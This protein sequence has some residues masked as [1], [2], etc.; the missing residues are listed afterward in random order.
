[1]NVRRFTNFVADMWRPLL[2]YCGLF[3]AFAV[4]LFWRIGSL[5]PGY[6]AA[7]VQAFQA[8]SSLDAIFHDPINAPFTL[9]AHAL[10]YL[11]DRGYLL[12][13]L[14]ATV[15]GLITLA[16]FCWLVQRWYGRRT[17]LLSTIL[18]GTSAWFLH[19]ARMG[20]PDVLLFGVLTLV[21]CSV[22][23]RRTNNPIALLLCFAIA[24]ALLYVPGMIAVLI[25]GAIWHWQTIDTIFK[26]HLWMVSL[27]GFVLLAA[28]APIAWA[29][30]KT[31][32]LWKT[33]VGL[34]ATGWPDV[35]EV[36]KNLYE[37]PA[38]FFLR[39]TDASPEQWLGH[40]PILDAF[41][42]AM[43]FIG[44][45][46]CIKHWR[47]VRV[48]QL[49]FALIIGLALAS[50]GGAVSVSVLV[51]FAYLLAATGIA[52]LLDQW[53]KVFPRNPIAQT[54]GVGIISITVLVASCYYLRHYFVAWPNN[55]ETKAVYTVPETASSD[56]IEQ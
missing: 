13:R 37:I 14:A 22:W 54:L 36:L 15:F 20:T 39:F 53:F 29:I 27:G 35:T 33:Y 49:V 40:L 3:G 41:S 50:L 42:M 30:Y 16:A 8:S 44:V 38:G 9:V 43:V 6:S 19:T 28:L 5:L 2:L 18:F 11:S 21:A 51:P 34:P 47:L 7:E 45:Y 12:T 23:L 48:K 46:V 31:P 24:A 17:A 26:R 25:L 1:M 55:S 52:Y 32:E 4:L 56:K 10:T